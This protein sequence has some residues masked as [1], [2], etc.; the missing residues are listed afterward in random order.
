MALDPTPCGI[1]PTLAAALIDCG[2]PDWAPRRLLGRR[3][4]KFSLWHRLLLKGID[5]PFL[6]KG[7]V[8]WRD[9]RTAVGIC[10]LEYRDSRV[11][12]PWLIPALIW[13]GII[14]TAMV[15]RWP[16]RRKTPPGSPNALQRAL[17]KHSAAFLDYCGDYLQDPEYYFPPQDNRDGR[18]PP[19]PAP[20]EIEQIVDIVSLTHWPDAYIWNLP[21]GYANWLQKLSWKQKTEMGFLDEKERQFQKEHPELREG[22]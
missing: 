6:K 17:T 14:L 20:Q 5:S 22:E 4:R 13:V 21:L 8:T 11:R 3:V 10:R 19:P 15:P 1:D 18:I 2:G 7:S 16:F 9:L 12:K